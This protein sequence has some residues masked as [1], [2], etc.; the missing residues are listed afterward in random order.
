MSRRAFVRRLG[1]A[2]VAGCALVVSSSVPAFTTES[3]A[4]SSLDGVDPLGSERTTVVQQAV[5]GADEETVLDEDFSE[6]EIPEGWDAAEGDWEVVDDRLVGTSVD[7]DQNARIT[8]GEHYEHYRLETTLRF[9]DA[10]DDTR[11]TAIGLDMPVSGDEPWQQAAMRVAASAS[12]GVEFAQRDEGWNVTNSASAPSDAGIGNDV[13]VAIAVSGEQARWYFNGE[14]VLET[15]ELSRSSDGGQGLIVNNATVA[16]DE[17]RVIEIEP[18]DEPDE[19]EED[20]GANVDV[21][22]DALYFEDFSTGDLPEG[23]TVAE[24]EW[25]VED[26]RLYGSSED[27]DQQSRLT[28]AENYEHFRFET[29]LRFESADDEARWA[30]LGLDIPA[31]GSEPW[32]N[33]T[34]RVASDAHNGIEFAE[35]TAASAWNVIDVGSAPSAAGIGNDV[36]VAV[37]VSGNRAQWYFEDELV[38]ETNRMNRSPE[39]ILGLGVNGSTI[40]FDHVLV[41]EIDPM[42]VLDLNEPGEAAAVVGHRG[43]SSVA[44][45]NTMPA[46]VSSVEGGADFFEIDI[47]YTADGEIVAIHDDTVDRTTD[48]TGAIRELTYEEVSQLDAGSWFDPTYSYAAVPKLDEVFAYM[49]ETGAHVL[50]EYKDTWGPEEA[51]L[52]A[53]LIE[54]YGV[55]DQIIAQSFDIT[56]L[57]NLQDQLPDVPRMVLGNIEEDAIA[58]A[59]DLDAIGY[60]PP[61]TDVLENPEW[62]SEAND[63]GLATFVWTVNEAEEWQ[64]LTGLG[65]EGIITDHPGQLMG[66]NERYVAGDPDSG[67]VPAIVAHRGNSGV[68]PEN[69][70]PAVASAVETGVEYFEIDIFLTADGIPVVLHDET[71]ERT[72]DGEGFIEEMTYEEVQDLDA[73]SWFANGYGYAGVHVPTLEDVLEHMTETDAHLLLEYKE[74]WTPEEVG[75]TREIIEQYGLA[76]QVV[77]Q[78]FGEATMEGLLQEMPEVPRMLLGGTDTSYIDLALELEAIAWN[79][80]AATVLESPELLEQAHE[81]GLYMFV[82]TVNSASQWEDLTD[83]GI[84]GIITDYPDRLQGWNTRFGQVV[85]QPDPEFPLEN[86]DDEEPDPTGTAEPT[87]SADPTADPTASESPSSGPTETESPTAESQPTPPRD[88]STASDDLAQTGAGMM[89]SLVVGSLLLLLLGAGVLTVIRRTQGNSRH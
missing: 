21:P 18:F 16:F 38:L 61:A 55:A 37:E 65:V 4:A 75:V 27:I 26:G 40:S 24:G 71:L 72:T 6:G 70:M 15:A 34:M 62:L 88:E 84:D 8:F 64:T 47:D 25:D 58:V 57:E 50:L 48:G 66:W 43:D 29:V 9:D 51:A 20:D 52:S 76:D 39:N 42:P 87:A 54:E 41:R 77:V 35:R 46:I 5:E 36:H 11:W 83:M 12:N 2:V 63:A 56:T 31:D 45:E 67:E 14:L 79:P 60:N 69:T 10:A 33:G 13:E 7:N 17:L 1:P 85:D 86:G 74:D 78:S 73:G 89:A 59:E 22:E 23:W 44:P 30:A 53:S 19:S 3:V 81:A 32:T 49:A 80:N 28:F 68:A 82:Y